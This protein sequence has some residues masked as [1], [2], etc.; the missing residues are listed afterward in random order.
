MFKRNASGLALCIGSIFI[1]TFIQEKLHRSIS[2]LDWWDL[3]IILI[4]LQKLLHLIQIC[5][6]VIHLSSFIFSQSPFTFPHE[7][8]FGG[9]SSCFCLCSSSVWNR[10]SPLLFLSK[11]YPCLE[12]QLTYH[13]FPN[14]I[15]SHLPPHNWCDLL[16]IS[17]FTE[18]KL[19]IN[20][21]VRHDFR[22]M[23]LLWFEE[24]KRFLFTWSLW[25][26]G[27]RGKKDK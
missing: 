7:P 13:F 16:L 4:K 27:Q 3:A 24:W 15:S 19:S 14:A 17:I 26:E 12:S 6:F 2:E 1:V 10:P 20:Y 9:T 18:K 5:E 25:F 21:F 8:D 23:E 22:V 11:I